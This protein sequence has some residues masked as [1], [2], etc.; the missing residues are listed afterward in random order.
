MN[1]VLNKNITHLLQDFN[2]FNKPNDIIK[3]NNLIWIIRNEEHLE[4]MIY[5]KNIKY[6][7]IFIIFNI[8]NITNIEKKYV[9]TVIKNNFDNT[10]L[11]YKNDLNDLYSILDTI[12]KNLNKGSLHNDFY[13][14]VIYSLLFFLLIIFIFINKNN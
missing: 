12:T 8:K 7:K 4:Q 13:I 5:I 10:N 1:I 11:F 6:N 2:Y 9:E 14:D 3:C